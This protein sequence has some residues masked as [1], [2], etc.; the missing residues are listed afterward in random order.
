MKK[1]IT[2]LAAAFILTNVLFISSCSDK[3]EQSAAARQNPV[4]DMREA[5]LFGF[6]L[7]LMHLS[8]RVMTNPVA[9]SERR[10]LNRFTHISGYFGNEFKGIL[11]PAP[12]MFYSCA[13]AALGK[14]PVVVSIPDTKDRYYVLNVMD[15]WRNIIFTA[16]KR[17]TGTARQ[18]YIFT[19]PGW[20]GKIEPGE[21]QVIQSP[22][23]MVYISVYFY[24]KN[25]TDGA[26][27]AVPLQK[28]LKITPLAN[29][30]DKSF[31]YSSKEADGK[32][33]MA[34][35]L[36]QIFKMELTDY[37]SLLNTLMLDNKPYPKDA[38]FLQKTAY[39]GLGQ[40]DKEFSIASFD[41]ETQNKMNMIPQEVKTYFQALAAEETVNGWLYAENAGS[42][43]T[44]YENRAFAA[45][46]SIAN[47][48]PQDFISAE[49]RTDADG[50]FLSGDKKYILHFSKDSIPQTRVLWLIAA[51]DTDYNVTKNELNRHSIGS[52]TGLRYNGDGS[53]DIYIQ[54]KSPGK[55]KEAN[56]L[57]S[58]D[59]EFILVFNI[60][61][62]SKD[63]N[64]EQRE[65]PAVSK[66]K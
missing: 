18:H 58:P 51:Y 55:D 52:E 9:G 15:A 53:L 37:F 22:T 59:K 3:K 50:E 38:A 45:Y 16:G 46:Q 48:L 35:P 27:N 39:L 57:P 66:N 26:K 34:P 30:G 43:E 47:F 5:Y 23:N 32:I 60:Y 33:D 8:E 31:E 10:P 7:V 11:Y 49:S 44:D 19:A 42:F 12:G 24:T 21:M 63:I 20:D 56:W 40:D 41:A 4:E 2:C 29:Y 36:E 28:K 13:W 65:L 61:E 1:L 17:A 62:P 54:S 6:P 14:E 25:I 64:E